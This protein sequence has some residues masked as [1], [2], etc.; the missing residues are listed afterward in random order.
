MRK[1][2]KLMAYVCV[3]GLRNADIHFNLTHLYRYLAR[4]EI[5]TKEEIQEFEK[6]MRKVT[7]VERELENE[8]FEDDEIYKEE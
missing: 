4:E 7:S 3:K 5:L 8:L 1:E 2:W 6:L